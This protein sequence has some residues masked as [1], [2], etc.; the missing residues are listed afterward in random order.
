MMRYFLV[1]ILSISISSFGYGQEEEPHQTFQS[2][3][4]LKYRLH[5][6]FLNASYATLSLKDTVYNGQKAYP[7]VGEGRT[8]G[9]A[10]IF[11]KVE[12]VYQSIFSVEPIRP[13]YFIRDIDEGGYTKNIDIDFDFKKEAALIR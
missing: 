6:G 13:M 5:Y 12:D 3:E 11:F 2:G 8:T 7:A 1:F 9:F 10:S 4:W